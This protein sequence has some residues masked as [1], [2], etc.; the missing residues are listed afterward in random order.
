[1]AKLPGVE[2][3]HT[4]CGEKLGELELVQ[5]PLIGRSHEARHDG[6]RTRTLV[7]PETLE[8]L[9]AEVARKALAPLPLAG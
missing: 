5:R 8:F 9:R 7:T 4:I 1:M 6:R 3:A 2:S